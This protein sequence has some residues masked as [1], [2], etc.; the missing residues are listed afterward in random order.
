MIIYSQMS[1]TSLEPRLSSL[2][3]KSISWPAVEKVEEKD[4]T[5]VGGV[6]DENV[7]SVQSTRNAMDS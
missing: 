4:E 5:E 3:V 2:Q 7:V 1:V 6:K